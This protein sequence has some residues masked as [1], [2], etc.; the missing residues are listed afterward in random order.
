LRQRCGIEE[1][2]PAMVLPT[3]AIHSGA[4][5][6]SQG[7]DLWLLRKCKLEWALGGLLASFAAVGDILV[8]ESAQAQCKAV[9][10]NHD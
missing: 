5:A 3:D 10:A 2:S 1:R 6:L 8:K 7:D 9:A 4:G